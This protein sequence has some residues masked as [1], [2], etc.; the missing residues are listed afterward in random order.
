VS[1]TGALFAAWSGVLL[2]TI[3]AKAMVDVETNI[4]LIMIF[5]LPLRLKQFSK[6]TKHGSPMRN[7]ATIYVRG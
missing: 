6:L 5:L 7:R 3:A 4:D 1:S 2:A